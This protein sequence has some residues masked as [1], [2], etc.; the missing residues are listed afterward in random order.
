MRQSK[1]TKHDC[2]VI[3]RM[4]GDVEQSMLEYVAA[5]FQKTGLADDMYLM[6]RMITLRNRLN[7]VIDRKV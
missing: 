4:I 5:G 3:Q 7:E 1:T 6:T 2:I